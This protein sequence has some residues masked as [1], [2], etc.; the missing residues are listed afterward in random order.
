MPKLLT[1]FCIAYSAG[2]YL[3]PGI[4]SPVSCGYEGS[5]FE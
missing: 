1:T 4:Y 2:V 3:C 5:I